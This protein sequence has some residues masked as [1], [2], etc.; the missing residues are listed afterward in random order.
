[1]LDSEKWLDLCLVCLFYGNFFRLSHTVQ[2]LQTQCKMSQ[3]VVMQCIYMHTSISLVICFFQA[4]Q[5]CFHTCKHHI[6]LTEPFHNNWDGEKLKHTCR[7]MI[8]NLNA[9]T[10]INEEIW[11]IRFFILMQYSDENQKQC[12]FKCSHTTGTLFGFTRKTK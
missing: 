9:N 6:R 5:S 11:I 2:K 7:Q 8:I 4:S 10:I 12:T 1:M 3:I